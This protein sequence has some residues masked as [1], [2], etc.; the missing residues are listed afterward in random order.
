MICNHDARRRHT[1]IEF[2]RPAMLLCA[3]A[4]VCPT[5]SPATLARS[6]VALHG[7]SSLTPL[8]REIEEQKQRLASADAEERRDALTRLGALARP[9]G[10][11]AAVTALS[12]SSAIVRVTAAH[13]LL[14]LP[15]DESATL[16]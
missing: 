6:R 10:S 2:I 8:Q 7:Q 4:I 1:L 13:A 14:S 9:E 12:D 16:L 5:L 15:A 3:A 11:R